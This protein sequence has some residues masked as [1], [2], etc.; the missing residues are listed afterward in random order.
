MKKLIYSALVTTGMVLGTI[1]VLKKIPY[2][3]AIV[4]S[5]MA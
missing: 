1:Y 5:L 4:S 2:T 3:S